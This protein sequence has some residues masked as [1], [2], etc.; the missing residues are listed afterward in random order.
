MTGRQMEDFLDALCDAFTPD[1]LDQMLRLRLNKDRAQLAGSGDLRT[2]AFKV[3]EAADRDGWE[4]EL[5]CAAC[6]YNPGN[7]TLRRF[8]EANPD[9][10][11]PT[12]RPAAGGGRRAAGAYP[13]HGVPNVSDPFLGRDDD[14][15][16][17]KLRLG[18]G[19]PD[20]GA[21]RVQVLTAM[22]GL[23]GVGKTSLAAWLAHDPEVRAA[24][25]HGVFWTSLGRNPNVLTKLAEWGGYLGDQQLQGAGSL[26]AATKRLKDLVAD[27]RAIFIVDDVWDGNDANPFLDARPSRGGLL[28]TTR[29]PGLANWSVKTPDGSYVLRVL[30]ERHAVELLRRCAPQ[31][32]EQHES[33]CAELV[34]DLGCL[35]LAL[36][37]AGRLLDAEYRNGW[38]VADLL[39]DLRDGSKILEQDAP[40]DCADPE[41]MSTPTV[42]A[43]LRKSTDRLDDE[44]RRCFAALWPFAP[45][46]ATFD[47]KRLRAVWGVPDPKRIVD[48]LVRRGLLEAL[49]PIGSGRFQVHALLAAHAKKL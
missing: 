41:T 34:R 17:L 5:A 13:A 44:T 24:F 15:A 18:I 30:E 45:K 22:H 40:P 49:E 37:V 6:D 32:V 42:R 20:D 9:L 47:V 19:R 28:L 11:D 21:A 36:V 4:S 25:P 1:S 35:P 29:M 46:P 38:G 12:D 33:V 14:T 26:K 31:V 7:A 23:P 10:V 16:R 48:E 43:L 3:I 27:R 39:A 2:V 8:C